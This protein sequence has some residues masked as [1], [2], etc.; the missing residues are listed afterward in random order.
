MGVDRARPLP[1]RRGDSRSLEGWPGGGGDRE[2]AWV[3]Y[4]FVGLLRMS[5]ADRSPNDALKGDKGRRLLMVALLGWAATALGSTSQACGLQLHASS[6][7]VERERDLE[8][9]EREKFFRVPQGR[10]RQFWALLQLYT[11]VH[12]WPVYVLEMDFCFGSA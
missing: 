1:R 7:R 9:R 2:G 4:A 6:L 10:H 3:R 8:L 12:A 11:H 5:T